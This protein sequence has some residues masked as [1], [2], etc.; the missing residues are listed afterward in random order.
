MAAHAMIKHIIYAKTPPQL[1]KKNNKSGPLKNWHNSTDSHTR[2]K[3]TKAQWFGTPRRASKEYF[4][5]TRHKHECRKNRNQ[6]ATTVRNWCH[7]LICSLLPQILK[8]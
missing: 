8:E 3:R 1:E 7:I 2:R 6:R 5:P 4:E